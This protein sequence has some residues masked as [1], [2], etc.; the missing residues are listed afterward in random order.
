MHIVVADRSLQ[1]FTEDLEAAGPDATWSYHPPEDDE[2]LTAALVDADA[3]VGGRLPGSVAAAGRRLRFVQAA[4]AGVDAIDLGALD[5][6]VVVA[7][8]YEHDRS[9]AEYVVMA[10]LALSRGLLPADRALRQG[11]WLNPAR[12]PDLPLVRTLTGQRVGI[13]G[14]GHIG[15]EIARLSQGLGMRASALRRTRTDRHEEGLDFL[16]AP[17]DLPELLSGADV[18]VV[19]VPLSEQTRGLI[20]REQLALMRPDAVL[21]NVARGPVV[22]E[23]ALYT[24]LRDRTIAGAALD[25]WWRPPPAPGHVDLPTSLPF[26]ELDNVVLTPHVSGVTEDTFRRRARAIGANL[27]RFAAGEEVENRVR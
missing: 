9:I 25:V 16:G 8:V 5:T 10:I 4:G 23:E 22:D 13:V 1:R 3:F 20:G 6:D 24:A 18:V 19:C 27:A 12:E 26:A 11:H 14:Y 2:M 15:R 7:N 21:V 17:E